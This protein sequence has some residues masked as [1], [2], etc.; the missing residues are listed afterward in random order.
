MCVR[1]C[2]RTSVSSPPLAL[3]LS[4][5]LSP[6]L[7]HA[8]SPTLPH[9]LSPTRSPT[10]LVKDETPRLGRTE[11]GRS[12]PGP[13]LSRIRV[14]PSTPDSRLPPLALLAPPHGPALPLDPCMVAR[15]PDLDVSQVGIGCRG[16]L[17]NAGAR[18]IWAAG[19]TESRGCARVLRSARHF[20]PASSLSAGLV[21]RG[22]RTGWAGLGEGGVGGGMG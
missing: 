11:G 13:R 18:S 17:G 14:G 3:A 8:L 10:P 9:S 5:T 2:G 19:I 15:G 22:V 21:G 4:R 1:V 12:V 7:S 20:G 16:G 6:A